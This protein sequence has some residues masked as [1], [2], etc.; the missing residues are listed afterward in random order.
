MTR[1]KPDNTRFRTLAAFSLPETMVALAIGALGLSGAMA[2][3][4]EQLRLVKQSREASAASHSLTE[5][6][7][8]VREATWTQITDP[9]YISETLFSSVPRSIAPLHGFSETITI[10]AWP[11]RTAP[12]GPVLCIKKT[13]KQ[14]AEILS[15]GSGIAEERLVKVD[16]QTRWGGGAGKREHVRELTTILSS[17][18]IS[19]MNL[20]AMGPLG[21]GEWDEFSTTVAPSD[22]TRVDESDDSSKNVR[23][24]DGKSSVAG[25]T[26]S[27][28]NNSGN[29][30]GS[31]RGNA[32]G[33]SG[34]N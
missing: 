13:P 33:A 8:Q 1:A 11:P 31:S 17:G 4:S 18:G 16:V 3:N 12:D 2:I 29:G 28:A 10:T 34:K 21:G 9:R 26:G 20:P 30:G 19:R 6:L 14:A 5:R 15:T 24:S 25:T 32:S 7:E 22:T 23:T 27:S